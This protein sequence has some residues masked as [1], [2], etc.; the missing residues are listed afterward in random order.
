V[1]L[2]RD[3]GRSEATQESLQKKEHRACALQHSP[4]MQ[5][6][7]KGRQEKDAVLQSHPA[8]LLDTSVGAIDSAWWGLHQ[9]S[10]SSPSLPV[11]HLQRVGWVVFAGKRGQGLAGVNPCSFGTAHRSFLFVVLRYCIQS[12]EVLRSEEPRPNLDLVEVMDETTPSVNLGAKGTRA[13][14][15]SG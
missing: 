1:G 11:T 9:L 15:R 7:G 3:D 10:P 13:P 12:R 4:L 2:I 5:R 8:L 14:N 6:T